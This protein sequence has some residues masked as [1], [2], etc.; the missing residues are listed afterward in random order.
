VAG[1]RAMPD[2][3]GLKPRAVRAQPKRMRHRVTSM[4]PSKGCGLASDSR[5]GRR[6]G[7]H[8]ASIIDAPARAGGSTPTARGRAARQRPRAIG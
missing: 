2:R 8:R 7:F 5:A 4:A 1:A 3:L 6:A